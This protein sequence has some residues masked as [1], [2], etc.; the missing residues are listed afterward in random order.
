MVLILDGTA[1]SMTGSRGIRLFRGQTWV[2]GSMH[3]HGAHSV[4]AVY[5]PMAAHLYA[6]SPYLILQFLMAAPAAILVTGA[7]WAGPG[8]EL[9][10]N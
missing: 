7:C 8:C 1:V 9:G 6:F 3:A 5:L 2:D 4:L 10:E